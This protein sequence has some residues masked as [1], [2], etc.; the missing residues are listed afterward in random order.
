MANASAQEKT[1][2]FPALEIVRK[3]GAAETVTHGVFLPEAGFAVTVAAEVEGSTFFLKG[4]PDAPAKMVAFEP[5]TRLVVL[6]SE[7]APPAA[8]VIG[9][10]RELAHGAELTVVSNGSPVKAR[11]AGR[12]KSLDGKSMQTLPLTMLRIHVAD[13]KIRAGSPV[14]DEKGSLVGLAVSPAPNETGPWLALP[15]EAVVDVAGDVK[16]FGQPETAQL[17]VGLAVGTT[18]PRVAFVKPDSR[19][20]KA[21]IKSGD[22]ILRIGDRPVWDSLD[23]LDANFYFNSRTPLPIQLLR[24]VEIVNV[25]APAVTPAK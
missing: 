3:T 8:G 7:A 10:S 21:G 25:V 13:G 2:P 11:L 9:K 12:D 15:V 23:V 19:G 24:G 17:E 20:D 5:L 18:T 16:Q 1:S 14:L 4:T 22:V 6:K